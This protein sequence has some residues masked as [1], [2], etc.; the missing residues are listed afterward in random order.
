MPKGK[1]AEVSPG[2]PR[3]GGTTSADSTT[4]SVEQQSQNNKKMGRRKRARQVESCSVTDASSTSDNE[5]VDNKRK[6]QKVRRKPKKK[7]EIKDRS[8]CSSVS[9]SDASDE[10]TDGYDK[11]LLGDEEDR[12]RLEE[13]TEKEREEE[14]FR[15]LERREMLKERFKIEK[16][17]RK[18]KKLETK[19]DDSDASI[20]ACDLKS[21]LF[22]SDRETQQKE[23]TFPT[24]ALSDEDNELS[25]ESSAVSLRKT[26]LQSM[27][28]LKAKR[29]EKLAGKVHATTDRKADEELFEASESSLNHSEGASTSDDEGELSATVSIGPTI[30]TL[31]EL[32]ELRLSRYKISKL[33]HA[34]F[35]KDTAIGCFVRIG[36]GS[37]NG[38]P[39]YRV[40]EIVDVLETAKIYQLE[41]TKTNKGARLRHGNQE[42][43]YRFEYVSNSEFTQSEFNNWINTMKALNLRLPT[44]E[45]AKKKVADV[46]NALNHH[47]TDAEV[48]Q[49]L[50][51]KRR[52]K[53][54]QSSAAVRKATLLKQI[55]IANINGDKEESLRLENEIKELE[56]ESAMLER[57]R[58]A[59][60]LPIS[61][62]NERNR[63]RNLM[64]AEQALKMF[65]K[66]KKTEGD[67]FTRINTKPKV[68]SR[69]PRL[70]LPIQSSIS[71][72]SVTLPDLNGSSLPTVGALSSREEQTNI[73]ESSTI[74]DPFAMHNFEVD[75]LLNTIPDIAQQ[76]CALGAREL[77]PSLSLGKADP[78]K[79]AVAAAASDLLDY[80]RPFL[81]DFLRERK[82]MGLCKCAKKRV[83]QM[84]CYEHRVNV[85]EYCIIEEHARCIVQN[86]LSWLNDSDYDDT[87][88]LCAVKLSDP[89][90]TCVRL[91][92]LHIFHTQCL[93]KWAHSL[94]SNTA[95]AGYKCTLCK[96]MIFPKPNQVGPIVDAL[97]DSL[98]NLE[99][100]QVGL[101]RMQKVNSESLTNVYASLDIVE[102]EKEVKADG[103]SYRTV[104]G[105]R[106]SENEQYALD[107]ASS[108]SLLLDDGERKYRRRS[109]LPDAVRRLR[110]KLVPG[111]TQLKGSFHCRR[112]LLI[113][114]VF[115]IGFFVILALTDRLQGFRLPEQDVFHEP[116]VRIE[117]NN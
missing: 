26:R 89:N 82:G 77:A 24:S 101:N 107:D 113:F 27:Q 59:N 86:Y 100:A 109:R 60:A 33:V 93:D 32:S 3:W 35:F 12:R 34:P 50:Q 17:L 96:T 87:C 45:F 104:A 38:N 53:L 36:I 37:N 106:S 92:C 16:R 79:H 4:D 1:V 18:A 48:E 43:V 47:Y 49:M 95:P 114:I 58:A 81:A 13:M 15:R 97:K 29:E 84:F 6:G 25:F 102:K 108:T 44:L 14:L 10:F 80:V 94:P 83:T 31:S 111:K 72:P 51:E 69:A 7:K 99:W 71:S 61:K 21:P 54:I 117:K 112:T 42:R 23:E 11:D 91:L 64:D 75:I 116:N 115:V 39:V 20:G 103:N 90:F 5:G 19:R 105:R 28:D 74:H 65:A 68:Y 98:A 41:N 76:R 9:N 88:P 56:E 62:I 57:R 78:P 63:Q 70:S 2:E 110:S 66:E 22:D 30:Q 85:C 8:N 67:P 40:A 73:N 52:F 55:E 46:N